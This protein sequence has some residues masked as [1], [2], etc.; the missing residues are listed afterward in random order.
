MKRMLATY[1][2]LLALA[3][4]IA[5]VDRQWAGFALLSIMMVWFVH[6]VIAATGE[7]QRL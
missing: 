6:A 5:L 2:T 7:Q 1:L 3:G 4:A